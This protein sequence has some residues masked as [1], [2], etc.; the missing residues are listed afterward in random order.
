MQIVIVYIV[1]CNN[2]ATK[3]TKMITAKTWDEAEAVPLNKVFLYNPDYKLDP[4]IVYSFCDSYHMH[5]NKRLLCTTATPLSV[6]ASNA[7]VGKR[8]AAT[9]K[10]F[11]QLTDE[12]VYQDCVKTNNRMALVEYCVYIKKE[13]VEAF[14]EFMFSENTIN[15]PH[16]AND[17]MSESIQ[18]D[19]DGK[20]RMYF[21]GLGINKH[22]MLADIENRRLQNNI[23][24]E[25]IRNTAMAKLTEEELNVLGVSKYG[26]V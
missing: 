12:Q 7:R 26:F 6:F 22:E 3:D 11:S 25:A 8:P 15:Q 1:Y 17:T 20:V 2:K 16:Y 13:R 23:R 14:E 21:E 24:K 5:T 9:K 10:F 4:A 18:R 19:I